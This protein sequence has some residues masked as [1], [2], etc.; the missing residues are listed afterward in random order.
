MK[1][2]VKTGLLLAWFVGLL[3]CAPTASGQYIEDGQHYWERMYTEV[4]GGVTNYIRKTYHHDYDQTPT[5]THL[6]WQEGDVE[7][8][9]G[10]TPFYEMKAETH[11]LT[12]P[13]GGDNNWARDNTVYSWWVKNLTGSGMWY[14]YHCNG[15]RLYNY[16]D[17]SAWMPVDVEFNEWIGASAVSYKWIV[18][19]SYDWRGEVVCNFMNTSP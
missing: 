16:L 14:W 7:P 4:Y 2:K 8:T 5:W 17:H 12:W 11:N 1:S 9:P 10:E 6:C 19:N 18:P 3:A 15:D 13:A